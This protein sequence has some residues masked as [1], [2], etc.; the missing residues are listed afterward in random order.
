MLQSLA[1]VFQVFQT[2][3]IKDADDAQSVGELLQPSVQ[4]AFQLAGGIF[5][6]AFQQHGVAGLQGDSDVGSRVAVAAF[7]AGRDALVTEQLGQERVDGFLADDFPAAVAGQ[8]GVAAASWAGHGRASS[9]FG[10]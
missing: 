1:G 9:W 4:L 7:G 2:V 3:G 8:G 6:L 5:P 10:E